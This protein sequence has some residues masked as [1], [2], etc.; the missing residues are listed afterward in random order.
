MSD[1]IVNNIIGGRSVPP[2][3]G[4]YTELVDPCT[5]DV[6]GVAA[7][8]SR[9]DVDAA[10]EAA[11]EA[12]SGAWGRATPRERQRLM[13]KLADLVDENVD[14]LLDAELECT[15]KPRAITR[16]LEVERV[17]DQFRFF[18][19]AAR[20]MDGPVAGEYVDGFTSFVRR[21]PVGVVAQVTPWNYPLMMAAWK[22]APALAGGNAIV[23][24]PSDTTPRTTVMLAALCAEVFPPGVV[25]VIAGDRETGRAIVAHPRPNLVAITGS[26]RAGSEVMSAA[27]RDLKDVH[28]ELGGKA[29]ALVFS[30]ADLAAAVSGVVEAAFFNAGQD[31]TAVTR[32]LVQDTIADEFLSA[33]CRETRALRTGAPSEDDVFF[34]PLNNRAQLERVQGFIERL[35]SHATLECGG[36]RVDRAGFFFSPTVV[37]G[38]RQDDEI[39]QSEVFGP[40]VTVQTFSTEGEAL[41]L[42]NGVDYALTSSVWT[43]DVG[44]VMRLTAA[45][46][47]GAVWANCHMILPA[48]MPH[49]GFKRSGTG[50]DL[51]VYS[52][53][54]YTRVKHVMVR[55]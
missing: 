37:S 27:A 46:D 14:S 31:C 33:L 54:S 52:L 32:V 55:H 9:A 11:D 29:P 47:F 48:E 53:E 6:Y 21:E 1:L 42:A 43:Q 18:A 26:T 36:S 19:G 38:V 22:L 8:S 3:E 15:G 51:S 13:L 4:H 5:E 12:A 7:R 30:D 49:G 28:L 40:V 35:P 39:V 25:N 16:T 23:L 2:Q 44:R 50:K 34:G 10:F 17:A 20:T 24:K 41:D 45:L